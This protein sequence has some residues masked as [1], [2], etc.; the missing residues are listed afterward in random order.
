MA[1]MGISKF[2]CP[3]SRASPEGS[4]HEPLFVF[5][6]RANQAHYKLRIAGFEAIRANR[7]N[8]MK[9]GVPL[10]SDSRE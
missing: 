8:V 9:G 7:S 4:R 5:A 2:R 10:R 6:N 1:Q 3:N